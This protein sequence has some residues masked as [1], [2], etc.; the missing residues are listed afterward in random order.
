MYSPW[1]RVPTAW[2]WMASPAS[3]RV[4]R[5]A[6][7]SPQRPGIG[8]QA[9]IADGVVQGTVDVVGVEDHDLLSR[10]RRLG[11]GCP[12]RPSA[13]APL[14]APPICPPFSCIIILSV[15]IFSAL[16]VVLYDILCLMFIMVC[17]LG[18]FNF[19]A[20]PA[21]LPE[22]ESLLFTSLVGAVFSS[23][24]VSALFPTV[25]VVSTAL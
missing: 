18:D 19:R 16:T 15:F 21:P 13:A 6:P 22:A 3:T 1:E 23:T 10:L 2:P 17:R 20:H 8:R 14:S 11:G 24:V 5:S 7:Y 25:I 9:G 12:G 4:T